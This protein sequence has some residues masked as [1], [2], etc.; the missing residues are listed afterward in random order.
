MPGTR[1]PGHHEGMETRDAIT[2]TARSAKLAA[3]ALAALPAAVVAACSLLD[4]TTRG[5]SLA[6]MLF[7]AA[8]TLVL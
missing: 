3:W 1:A 5:P 7:G 8:R 2:R 6:P 4:Q